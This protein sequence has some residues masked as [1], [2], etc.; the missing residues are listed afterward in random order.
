MEQQ[1]A[2]CQLPIFHHVTG[3]HQPV[4]YFLTSNMFGGLP[5]E[6]AGGDISLQVGQP[7]AEP[8]RHEVDEI[9]LLIS[10]VPGEAVIDVNIQGGV[11]TYSSPSVIHV[12]AGAT[13]QFITRKAGLGSF[14]FG[15]LYRRDGR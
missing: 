8:H 1:K 6:L 5:F 15:I 11:K 13:H 3:H 14:C 2:Y 4:P 7:V 12:P 10:P 9:Y